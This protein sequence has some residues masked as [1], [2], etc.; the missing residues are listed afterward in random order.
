[1]GKERG[2]CQRRRKGRKEA[3]T[4]GVA[5]AMAQPVDAIAK[6]AGQTATIM[7]LLKVQ[8]S[9]HPVSKTGRVWL[10]DGLGAIPKRVYERMGSNGHE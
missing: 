9:L 5:R 4:L 7:S 1:M 6:V 3:L 8:E 10:G 2:K